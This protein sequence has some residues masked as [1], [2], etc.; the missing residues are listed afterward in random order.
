M[1]KSSQL[2]SVD[3][4]A[5]KN[6]TLVRK[7]ESFEFARMKVDFAECTAYG[8]DESVNIEGLEKWLLNV[9]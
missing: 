7:G 8:K 9:A 6:V 4:K 2:D 5:R 3:P 1:T